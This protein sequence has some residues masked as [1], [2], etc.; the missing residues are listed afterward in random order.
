MRLMGKKILGTSKIAVGRK[1]SLLKEV[2][3][4]LHADIGDTVVFFE[5]NGKIIIEKA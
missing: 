5:E 2:A 3:D 1:I 4:K